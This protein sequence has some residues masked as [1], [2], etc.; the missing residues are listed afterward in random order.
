MEIHQ[1]YYRFVLFDPR[2]WVPFNDPWVICMFFLGS[3][4][5]TNEKRNEK[6]QVTAQSL[7]KFSLGLTSSINSLLGP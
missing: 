2:K 6:R 7:K 1:N 3:T 5:E 4:L